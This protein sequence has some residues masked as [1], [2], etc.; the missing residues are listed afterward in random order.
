MKEG[1]KKIKSMFLV[2]C[3]LFSAFIAIAS[4]S[5]SADEDV[6]GD[7]EAVY[8]DNWMEEQPAIPLDADKL[9]QLNYHVTGSDA[10]HL[11]DIDVPVRITLRNTHGSDNI[12]VDQASLTSNHALFT[13]NDDED[14]GNTIVN[15][16]GTT[17]FDFTIDIGTA[18]AVNFLY[19]GA[20][21]LNL[22][23]MEQPPGTDINDETFDF[24]IY[25]SSVFDD[26]FPDDDMDVHEG[27]PYI[28]ETPPDD[29]EFEAGVTMQEGEMPLTE[30]ADYDIT[31]VHG[32]LSNLATGVTLSGGQAEAINPTGGGSF[33]LFWR[34]DVPASTIPGFYSMDCLMVYV[35]DDTGATITENARGTGLYVDFTPRVTASLQTP[36]TI[37]QIDDLQA[38]LDVIFTN[39][40]NVDLTDMMVYP[41]PDMDWLDVRFHH[42]ENDDDTYVTEFNIGALVVGASSSAVT[43]EIAAAMMLPNGDH[44]VPFEW[45]GW[46]YEDGSTGTA[47]RWVECGAYM[48]DHDTDDE[49]PEVGR[50]YK[51]INEDGRYDGGD[52]ELEPIWEGAW[53]DFTVNDANGLTWEAFLT[54]PATINA[55]LDGDVMY[56]TITVTIYNKELVNYKDL[57]VTLETGLNLPFWDPAVE[58]HTESQLKMDPTSMTTIPAGT[59]GTPGEATIDFTV[60]VNA[61]W[62]KANSVSPETYLVDVTVNATNDHD[63]TR[64]VGTV[65]PV[66]FDITGF[67]PELFARAVNYNKDFKP[68]ATFALTIEITNYGDDTAREVD[69]YLRAD[70]I[71]GWEI[72]DQFVTSISSYGARDYTGSGGVGDASWGWESDWGTY[73]RFN[74][75]N[76]IKPADL[77]VDDIPEMVELYDWI[78][79]RETPPQGIVLWM[80][81]DRLEPGQ[82]HNFVFEMKSDVNMVEGM[83]YYETLELYYVDSNGEDYGPNGKPVGTI[84]DHYA[85]PQQVL[86]R[87]GTGEVYTGKDE[88]DWGLVLNAII[89]AIIIVIAFILGGAIMGGR[90]EKPEK[91]RPEEE[92]YEAPEEEYGPP[93]APEDELGPPLPEENPPE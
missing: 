52:A 48:Y 10:Y 62:W 28:D 37:N 21:R 89:F 61:A 5:V 74:R 79:R 57:E 70:F 59:P 38:T 66:K 40:G 77:D 19:V 82:T 30:Y 71:A 76:E 36:V 33:D 3:L 47:T 15:S 83:A 14:D 45:N 1:K 12:Y 81:V 6:G 35:R 73:D 20:L 34:F 25:V 4:I 64:I 43:V 44:R 9:I 72:V 53:V 90:R 7:I 50:L 2:V 13:V 16:G 26:D 8:D 85:P 58:D 23:D 42:Y 24:D 88:V 75:T 84:E 41:Q 31:D 86:I 80:H 29:D 93:P 11:G 63:E 55:G 91:H 17:N 68:G 51:D 69:A 46:Y 27:L 22:D 18:G 92:P 65:I 60:D 32:T 78:R 56:T 49:T 87:A 54:N 39:D 67:G